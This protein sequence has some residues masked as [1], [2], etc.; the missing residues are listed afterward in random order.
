LIFGY[1]ANY[2]HFHGVY[3]LSQGQGQTL[4]ARASSFADCDRIVLSPQQRSICP[5]DPAWRNLQRPDAY[6]TP[7]SP[8]MT[9]CPELCADTFLT[10]FAKTVIR[11]Q[12]GDYVRV[13][14]V[15]TSWHFL[16]SPPVD[17]LGRCVIK[18]WHLP[19]TPSVRCQARMYTDA[20]PVSDEALVPVAATS[21]TTALARYSDVM[22]TP[23]PL[24]AA[25]VLAAVASVCRRR[26]RDG[27]VRG[28][29]AVLFAG[30]GLLLVL[31]SVA[32]GMYE[33]RYLMPALFLIPV[34]AALGL[35][36]LR[37]GRRFTDEAE[38]SPVE[39]AS[40]HEP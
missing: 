5:A 22:M 21:A 27:S 4:A 10:D 15:Q 11:Q 6:S 34:G 20:G 26:W 30:V 37:R 24:L 14:V 9:H 35:E 3:A 19:A 18:S 29:N 16:P 36:Q 23:G 39:K 33:M 13:V 2:H 31:S 1:M 12:F 38:T 17:E 8:I 7:G 28:I 40:R 32:T 25:G